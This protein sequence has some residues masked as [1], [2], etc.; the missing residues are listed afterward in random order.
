MSIIDTRRE[1]MFPVL[2][3][4][5]VE[6]AKRFAQRTGTGFRTGRCRF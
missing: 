5:Q 2:D 6:T 1:Q 3:A 4:A